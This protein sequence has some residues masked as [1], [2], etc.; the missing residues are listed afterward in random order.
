MSVTIPTKRDGDLRENRAMEPQRHAPRCVKRAARAPRARRAGTFSLAP[1]A[2]VCTLAAA[3]ASGCAS[4]GPASG[5]PTV[6]ASDVPAAAPQIGAPASAEPAVAPPAGASP[7]PFSGSPEGA[8]V[9][10]GWEPWVIHP[11]KRKTHYR[12]SR[13]GSRRVLVATAAGAASGLMAKV[14]LDPRA[15]PILRWRWRADALVSDADNADA[16]REDAPV[17]IVL[18]FD[19]DKSRLPMRDRM[20]FERVK[21]LSGNEMPHS[22][23]MYIWENRRAVGTVIENPHSGRIRKIVVDSGPAEL[24][25]WRMHR[26]D[27]VEDYRRAFGAEPGRL[28]G[29]AILTDT[30]NTGGEVRASYGDIE[31]V[32][33]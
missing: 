11:R 26:R 12:V 31:L 3:L 27:I 7:A 10:V 20:F 8:E 24:R 18:A 19:G 16:S 25:R 2:A 33:R 32:A 9:P 6:P 15:R 23:L 30:D 29:I 13:D 17:R 21:L 4:I 14:E 1:L 22:T 28:I 5:P